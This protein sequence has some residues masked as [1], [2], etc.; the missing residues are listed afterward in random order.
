MLFIEYLLRHLSKLTDGYLGRFH[1]D[2]RFVICEDVLFIALVMVQIVILFSYFVRRLVAKDKVY[3]MMQFYAYL[4]ALK[5]LT[6]LEDE[7]LRVFGPHWQY[8]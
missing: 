7:F 2:F 8:H 1:L 3:P 6:H 4:R 5:Y